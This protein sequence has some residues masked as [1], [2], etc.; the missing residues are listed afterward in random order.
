MQR[1]L[2]CSIHMWFKPFMLISALLQS[3]IHLL[4]CIVGSSSIRDRAEETSMVR[5]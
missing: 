5:I 4:F 3:C 1:K 2:F